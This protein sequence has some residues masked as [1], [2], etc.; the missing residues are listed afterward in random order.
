MLN[1]PVLGR[2]VCTLVADARRDEQLRSLHRAFI[3]ERRQRTMQLIRAAVDRGQ[4]RA[5][6]DAE[7]AADL[8]AAP[9]FYRTMNT[10]DPLDDA[11]LDTVVDNVMRVYGT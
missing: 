9:L 2:A 6:T 1:D 4:L 8:L 7:V 11:Y 10:G 5:D 3:A